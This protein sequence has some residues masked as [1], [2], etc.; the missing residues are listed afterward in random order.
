MM[1]DA[2]HNNNH[3]HLARQPST[4]RHLLQWWLAAIVDS[5][6]SGL[7]SW[8]RE[9][10]WPLLVASRWLLASFLVHASLHVCQHCLALALPNVATAPAWEGRT[11]WRKPILFGISNAFVFVALHRALRSQRLVPRGPAAHAAAWCTLVEV[12]VITLQAWR[13]VPSHFN[14]GTPLDAALYTVKLTGAAVLGAVCTGALAGCVRRPANDIPRA[15]LAAL[16]A[17]MLLLFCAVLVGVAQVVYGHRLLTPHDAAT[18]GS[19]AVPHAAA[20]TAPGSGGVDSGG[21]IDRAMDPANEHECRVVTAG[22]HGAPCYEVYGRA[23]LKILHFLPLHSTEAL[24]VLAWAA[25]RAGL[26]DARA[27]VAV[28]TAAAG[29]ALLT[30]GALW[31]T[32]RGSALSLQGLARLQLEAPAAVSVVS[33]VLLLACTFGFVALAPMRGSKSS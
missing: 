30:S 21:V 12:G 26:G 9:P 15:D 23:R 18:T 8:Q 29:L 27:V 19:T 7:S 25:R 2:A 14:I 32:A 6:K 10:E 22:A 5:G 24:L 4:P 11:G 3:H 33:G 13:G 16:R 28:R 31:Q 1:V 20:A 17:G